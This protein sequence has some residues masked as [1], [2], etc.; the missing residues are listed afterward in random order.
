METRKEI[1]MQNISAS[2][3]KFD[4]S[5]FKAPTKFFHDR[6]DGID[7]FNKTWQSLFDEYFTY[8]SIIGKSEII[9]WN[10][11]DLS[12]DIRPICW[13]NPEY[14]DVFVDKI[15]CIDIVNLYPKTIIRCIDEQIVESDFR[16]GILYKFIVENRS[17]FK[18]DYKLYE[19]VKILINVTYGC[20]G[21]HRSIIKFK[22][23]DGYGNINF[24]VKESSE[25]MKRFIDNYNVIYIDTDSVYFDLNKIISSQTF[26]ED[27]KYYFAKYSLQFD[28][29]TYKGV[30]SDRKR[31]MLIDK[32]GNVKNKMKIWGCK[33][34]KS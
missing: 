25:I 23:K 28:F 8:E 32:N 10:I 3:S 1:N 24:V 13:V 14:K 15:G 29:I 20:V 18:Y 31:Y 21:N 34:N 11:F 16:F 5:Y 7:I 4:L 19:T 30:F 27:A 12:A 6:R 26:I 17:K 2:L 22:A 9:T 33:N